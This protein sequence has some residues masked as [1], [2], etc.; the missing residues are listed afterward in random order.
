VTV[1]V[2]VAGGVPLAVRVAVLEALLAPGLGG[3]VGLV[4]VVPLPEGMALGEGLGV[5]LG[6]G[7]GVG[8]GAGLSGPGA[9]GVGAVLGE[10]LPVGEMLPLGVGRKGL[11]HSK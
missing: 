10:E 1:G 11:G 8:L 9:P 6:E 4:D 3:A 7:L 5:G 2:G